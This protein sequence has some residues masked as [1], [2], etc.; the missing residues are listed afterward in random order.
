MVEDL[1]TYYPG[2]S[3]DSLVTVIRWDNVEGLLIDDYRSGR[4]LIEHEGKSQVPEE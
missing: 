2:F 1:N 3:E 4:I